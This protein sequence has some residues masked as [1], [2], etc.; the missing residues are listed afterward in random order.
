MKLF[1]YIKTR[2]FA[3]QI[4]SHWK[5][6]KTD[7]KDS[8]YKLMSLNVQCEN[9]TASGFDLIKEQERVA[10]RLGLPE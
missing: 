4:R 6:V 3:F 8:K 10:A 9:G 2:C 7:F 5:Q 1:F